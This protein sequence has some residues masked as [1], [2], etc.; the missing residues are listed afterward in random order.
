MLDLIRR[1]QKSILVKVVFWTIIAAFVGTIFLVWGKGADQGSA[2]DPET[3][4]TVNGTRISY[5]E[6][7]SAYSNLY[8]LYQDVYREKFTPEL[9]GTLGLRQQALDALVEQTL[10]RQEAK[11]L[12][13]KV[14]QQEL[15]GSIA[16]IPAFQENG[17]FSRELYLQVLNAQR[18]NPEAFETMQKHQ[19]LVEK[20]REKIEADVSVDDAAVAQEYRNRNE[21]INLLFLRF[22]PADYE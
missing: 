10:L 20:L 13:L 9:E 12:G 11:R 7:Q 8:R 22:S 14:S 19:L 3:A 4:A 6:Y 15:V 18:L 5:N 21:K 17:S 2:G 16:E 1:K